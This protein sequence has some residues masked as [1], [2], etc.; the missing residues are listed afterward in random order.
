[1]LGFPGEKCSM[2]PAA[3]LG[4]DKDTFGLFVMTCLCWLQTLKLEKAPIGK[5]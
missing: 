5:P 3:G 4:D 2:R 1:M